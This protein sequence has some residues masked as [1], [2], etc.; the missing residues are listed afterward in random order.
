M[1]GTRGGERE[2]V[3]RDQMGVLELKELFSIEY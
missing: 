2:E 3:S 1:V